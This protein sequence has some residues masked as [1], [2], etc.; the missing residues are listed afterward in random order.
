LVS[1]RMLLFWLLVPFSIY[2]KRR[3]IS[4][5]TSRHDSVMC[6][7]VSVSRKGR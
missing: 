3:D 4:S 5:S 7:S 2:S 6:E 1:I